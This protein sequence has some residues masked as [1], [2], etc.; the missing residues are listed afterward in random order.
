MKTSITS[1]TIIISLQLLGLSFI[2]AKPA[3]GS[4]EAYCLAAYDQVIG[5]YKQL[6]KKLSYRDRGKID[7]K[8]AAFK[9][10]SL[11]R[12]S[13]H[14]SHT[15]TLDKMVKGLSEHDL[16][17]GVL[18]PLVG[19]RSFN[20]KPLLGGMYAA[21]SSQKDAMGRLVV[22]DTSGLLAKMEQGLARLVFRD[23]VSLL[24]GGYSKGEAK[25]LESWGKKLRIPTIIVNQRQHDKKMKHVFHVFPQKKALVDKLIEHVKNQRFQKIALLRPLL[26]GRKQFT[27]LFAEKLQQA[28][29]DTA[30]D[31]VY[32][33]GEY[34]SMEAAAKKVFQIDPDLRAEEYEELVNEEKQRALETGT[35]YNHRFVALPPIVDVDAIFIDDNF[36]AVK[37]FTKIFHYLGVKRIHLI[38]TPQWRAK[39]LIEPYSSFLKGAH[40]VDFVGDYRNLPRKLLV[41]DLKDPYFVKPELSMQLDYK[42]IGFQAARIAE[43]ALKLKKIPRRKLSSRILKTQMAKGPYFPEG[44]IFD[45]EHQTHWPVFLF[46]VEKNTIRKAPRHLKSRFEGR[47]GPPFGRQPESADSVKAKL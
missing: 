44:A 41:E 22:E 42:L 39:G 30:H 5:T 10:L 34:A 27:S 13:C 1:I 40:F 45:E 33:R 6:Y 26:E 14:S 8:K 9:M 18:L 7:K 32:T 4:S 21:F 2:L 19:P 29:I 12:K 38:G 37:H 3:M 43:S 31:Y 36:R 15:K 47:G 25:R 24:I 23:R 17:I 28:G 20:A 35:S 46:E 16:K 11:K